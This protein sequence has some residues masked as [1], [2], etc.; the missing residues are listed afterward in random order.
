L[1][2]LSL[3]ATSELVKQADDPAT[4]RDRALIGALL[5]TSEALQNQR[6]LVL[7]GLDV[8]ASG[9]AMPEELLLQLDVV[10]NASR[11]GLFEARSLAEGSDLEEV[12][13]IM[14]GDSAVAT[15]EILAQIRA[16]TAGDSVVSHEDWFEASSAQIEQVTDLTPRVLARELAVAQESLDKAEL[17]LWTVSILL[18]ALFVLSILVASNAVYATR[19][20]GEALAEYGQLADGLREWF[21]AASFPDNDNVEIAAR[22]IPASVRT[23]SG[24]DWY[25]VYQVGDDLAIVI[26]DVAG[27]GADATAQMAQVRNILRGQ[28]TARTLDPA[29]QIDLL[30]RTISESGIL[31]TLTYGLLNPETGEFVYT[32]AGHIPLLIRS[33]SGSVRIEEEAPGPPVGAG[34]DIEREQEITRLRPGDVLILITDGLVEGIDR[35]IDLALDEMAKA[36][37]ES[38][39]SSEALLDQLFSMNLEDPI[40]D[41]AALLITWR[42]REKRLR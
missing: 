20:R 12:E 30:S 10:T 24:G 4:S 14:T 16:D 34:V 23:M 38:E 29:A 22:Y 33:A 36:L 6:Y 13:E 28:S 21:V 8:L 9:E 39:F 2:G 27:H 7:A 11:Q 1:V 19:E 32:R 26:G 18:G 25:D 5:T 31:A 42:P 3:S 17:A 35:D 41:A 15:E 37:T 40:D